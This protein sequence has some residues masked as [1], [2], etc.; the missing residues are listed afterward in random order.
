MARSRWLYLTFALVALACDQNVPLAPSLTHGPQ[1]DATPFVTATSQTG[2]ITI[3]G[4]DGYSGQQISLTPY[5]YKVI[6]AITLSG[7]AHFEGD[8]QYTPGHLASGDVGP[9][10]LLVGQNCWLRAAVAFR[11]GYLAPSAACATTP[12]GPQ[13]FD[14]TELIA[15]TPV[16]GVGSAPSTRNFC[17]PTTICVTWS[18]SEQVVIRPTTA[19]L[20]L[21]IDQPVVDSGTLVTA[22]A[23]IDPPAVMGIAMPYSNLDWQLPDPAVG[24]ASTS[25]TCTFTATRS[26]EIQL[27]G[28]VNGSTRNDAVSLTVRPKVDTTHHDSTPSDS[29]GPCLAPRRAVVGRSV[30]GLKTAGPALMRSGCG[31]GG[32]APAAS[33]RCL[34]GQGSDTVMRG[35]VVIC[36]VSVTPPTAFMVTQWTSHGADGFGDTNTN[37]QSVAAGGIA[38][39]SGPA[40]L[41][42]Q[43]A[44]ELTV[45]SG[46][47]TKVLDATTG[48]AV[49]PRP[50]RLDYH[51]R[52]QP[53]FVD[54]PPL[55]YPPYR[56]P[57]L[58]LDSALGISSVW[59]AASDAIRLP[60]PKGVSEGPNALW[61]YVAAPLPS[62]TPTA[63]ISSGFLHSDPW[64]LRQGPP[65]RPGETTFPCTPFDLDTV[66]AH[67]LRHEGVEPG[68]FSHYDVYAQQL[69]THDI[70]VRLES[71][72]GFAYAISGDSM[73][74][75][76]SSAFVE[77]QSEMD[78]LQAAVDV[79]RVTIT[80]GLRP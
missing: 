34:N 50:W 4:S 46:A 23:T 29:T 48:F 65:R 58:S 72:T 54:G 20:T 75:L 12:S 3:S 39:W 80:C 6:A 24:C 9:A 70:N 51:S 44:V 77:W 73:Q 57:S 11:I 2:T 43:V 37:Q 60:L 16:F 56:P 22:T 28:I 68:Q 71:L 7:A 41:N 40:V 38:S 5:D 74:K 26:G 35:D 30:P 76:I 14:T 69:P 47:T 33:L 62:A 53:V 15:G 63:W 25:L 66:E 49:A 52:P 8:T 21:S 18:G 64:F 45:Q 61:Q 27:S 32:N 17:G 78:K 59:S 55:L 10:G 42:S 36:N 19:T 13:T 31:G 1:R 79:D 67:V